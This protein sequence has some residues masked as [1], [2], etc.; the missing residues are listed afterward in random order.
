MSET[1]TRIEKLILKVLYTVDNESSAYLSRSTFPVPVKIVEFTPEMQQSNAQLPSSLGVAYLYDALNQVYNNSPELFANELDANIFDK[2]EV[3]ISDKNEVN[4]SDMNEANIKNKSNINGTNANEMNS[5]KTS[6]QDCNVKYKSH[7]GQKSECS[8]SMNL[9]DFNVYYKD[10]TEDNEPFVSLG[11]LSNLQ[12]VKTPIDDPVANSTTKYYNEIFQDPNCPLVFG[13][14]CTNFSSFIRANGNSSGNA[15][16]NDILE[17]KLRFSRAQNSMGKSHMSNYGNNNTSLP[18]NYIIPSVKASFTTRR[19]SNN[20][21]KP[22]PVRKTKRLTNPKPAPKA[23]KTQSLP[24]WNNSMVNPASTGSNAN[25]S[26]G[27]PQRRILPA[28][29]IIKKIQQGDQ[30]NMGEMGGEA[31][32]SPSYNES[33]MMTTYN[34]TADSTPIAVDVS[35][36]FEFASKLKSSKNNNNVINGNSNN[37]AVRLHGNSSS[38]PLGNVSILKK[39]KPL[40]K[41]AS[42]TNK[43]KKKKS[44]KNAQIRPSLNAQPNVDFNSTAFFPPANTHVDNFSKIMMLEKEDEEDDEDD[45]DIRT[46]VIDNPESKDHYSPTHGNTAS[47]S[48]AKMV[49]MVLDGLPILEEE[50]HEDILD[51]DMDLLKHHTTAA[52]ENTTGKKQS[53]KRSLANVPATNKKKQKSNN[54]EPV[55]SIHKLVAMDK[56]NIIPPSAMDSNQPLTTTTGL[57][58]P[59]ITIDDF[60]SA[61]VYPTIVEEDESKNLIPNT[62]TLTHPNHQEVLDI[63]LDD[64]EEEDEEEDEEDGTG[65]D[66]TTKM[67]QEQWFNDFLHAEYASGIAVPE[68]EHATNDNDNTPKIPTPS[69]TTNQAPRHDEAKDQQPGGPADLYSSLSSSSLSHDY[70]DDYT[71]TTSTTQTDALVTENCCSNT[72]LAPST[73]APIK[74]PG[75][76]KKFNKPLDGYAFPTRISNNKHTRIMPSSPPTASNKNDD[77]SDV[78][79]A[80]QRNR[81]SLMESASST[82][83]NLNTAEVIQW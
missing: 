72:P 28:S 1:R 43:K 11:L 82:P 51:M 29:S 54:M 36:R 20:T 2:N 21:V 8:R 23:T 10:I 75:S 50:G 7:K 3:N 25:G 40:V 48:D 19:N 41:D 79:E 37:N 56:E 74:A 69:T 67:Q 17:I 53:K 18:T 14:I 33:V 76:S 31:Q 32:S 73:S 71:S 34:D 55:L 80:F 81:G 38:S 66:A 42:L 70:M 6:F 35:K 52:V 44:I 59:D 78:E 39:K 45:V 49:N 4:I 15:Y 46:N 63:A 13:R 77:N 26:S 83:G 65:N 58:L 22:V 27:I 61:H 12:S 60:F 9:P 16:T 47:N 5:L 57:V 24:I 62:N 68:Y 30:R 64:E